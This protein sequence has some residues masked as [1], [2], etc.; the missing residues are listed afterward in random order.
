MSLYLSEQGK[1]IEHQQRGEFEQLR[2]VLGGAIN[3]HAS[4]VADTLIELRDFNTDGA[5]QAS[6]LSRQVYDGAVIGVIVVILI[7]VMLTIGLAW[8]FTRSL[9]TPLH[10]AVT[11][12]KAVADG[13][14]TRVIKV[15]GSDEPAQLLE[16]LRVMQASLR[17]AV[18]QI[19]D[20]STQ[21]ASAA[22]ELSAVTESSSRNLIQQNE[23][24]EQAA[25]AVNQMTSAVEEV[26]RN[27]ADTSHATS[28]TNRTALQ[29]RDQVQQTVITIRQLSAGVN[30]SADIPA[31]ISSKNTTPDAV[32]H[33][34]AVIPRA[35]SPAV[36]GRAVVLTSPA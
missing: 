27:A 35:L 24:I 17:N 2:E 6:A 16:S 26:A 8:L 15:E 19:A 10:Q 32:Y 31:I 7:A 28:D 25:T 34:V 4:G 18:Q 30:A 12:A 11:E 14:L 33:H 5:S 23:Q 36:N 3:Q 1:A 20:S 29:G 9:V 21:L 13:D 22:E